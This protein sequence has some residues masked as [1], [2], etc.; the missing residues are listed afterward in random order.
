[1]KEDN[2][3]LT[4]PEEKVVKSAKD[5]LQAKYRIAFIGGIGQD[6]LNDILLDICHF[7]LTLDPSNPAMIA[8]YNVGLA[9]LAKCGI[10]G[11]L[12]GEDVIKALCTV[13]PSRKE[14]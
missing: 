8:E 5:K 4:E 12:T 10:L 2:F 11:P 7:G 9:I 13:A 1:M 3:D 14:S 6:V